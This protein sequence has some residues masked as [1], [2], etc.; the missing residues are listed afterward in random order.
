MFL[1]RAASIIAPLTLGLGV[2]RDVLAQSASTAS[3]APKGGTDGALP[4]AGSTE[5]TYILFMGGVILFVFGTIKLILSYR[6][7]A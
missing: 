3:S 4:N 7:H 5:L 2:V 1:A 6:D